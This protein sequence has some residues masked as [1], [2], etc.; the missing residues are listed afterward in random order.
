MEP[1]EQST[2]TEDTPRID[3]RAP[4][5]RLWLTCV[6]SA[7]NDFRDTGRIFDLTG[8]RAVHFGRADGEQLEA[9]VE[10]E[11]L[12]IHVPVGWVSSHH[13]EL[14][15]VHRSD[16]IDVDIRDLG[17]RNGTHLERQPVTGIARLAYG[18]IFELGRSFWMIRAIEDDSLP[19][20]SFSFGALRTSHPRLA[21][22]LRRLEALATTDVSIVL[23]GETGVGKEVAAKAI[24]ERSGRTGAYVALNLATLRA[25]KIETALLGDGN[26]IGALGRARGGTLLLDDLGELSDEAQARLVAT[27]RAVERGVDGG[28]LG[29]VRLLCATVHDLHELV[30][31]GC[32]RPDLHARV[33]GFEAY[34]PPVRHRREDFG[35]I[36]QAL[37]AG[38]GQRSRRLSTRA[39]RRVL[40]HPWAYNVRELAQTLSTAAILVGEHGEIG[41]E[42][43]DEILDR[44][45]DLPQDPGTITQLRSEL[46]GLL[47]AMH[48]D[49]PRI[50]KSMARE[51]RDVQRLLERFDLEPAS[52]EQTNDRDGGGPVTITRTS[53]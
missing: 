45:R 20:E 49:T 38:K 40:E 48:G 27:L 43:I 30:R 26:D 24:H 51:L 23:R 39:F 19:A 7:E 53:N 28:P 13:A 6:G 21:S 33:T 9:I 16:G 4:T 52:F 44:R 17:S 12:H 29:D 37:T 50:A 34:I 46:V 2:L 18:Q 32:F 10:D 14:R 25:D 31:A 11:T 42:V 47:G 41:V 22:M 8:V 35:H 3:P 15:L 1:R 36:L 5:R